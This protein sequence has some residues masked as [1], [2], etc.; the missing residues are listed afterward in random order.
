MPI[1][2]PSLQEK[3]DFSV[4]ASIGE[5]KGFDINGGFA[6]TDHFAVIAGLYTH[7][8]KD[9]EINGGFFSSGY[10]SSNLVY[11]HNG[12][13]IGAGSY[14]PLGQQGSTAYMSFFGGLNKGKFRMNENF[15]EISP[16]PSSKVNQY[17]S[18]LNRWFLQ[19]SLNLYGNRVESSITTRLNVVQ[20]KNV[21]TDYTNDE[22]TNFR[23]PPMVSKGGNTFIDFAFDF[24]AFYSPEIRLGVLFYFV[25][26]TRL[27]E[28][29]DPNNTK[30]FYY[31][32][33]Y[34]IG[35]G[36]FYRG[37]AGK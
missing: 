36:I 18:N 10:D 24:K 21:V 23:L 29:N 37:F 22:L 8:N 31:C 7:K 11:R 26:S 33:P 35:A 20:Y 14:F 3:N 17:T 30:S 15:Y 27:G 19:G 16:N 9:V 34:R 25:A 13:T 5:P 2:N 6:I 28:G 1:T 32:Y 12:F 4:N